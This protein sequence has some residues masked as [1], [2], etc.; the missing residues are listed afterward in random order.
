MVLCVACIPCCVPASCN[1]KPAGNMSS[2]QVHRHAKSWCFVSKTHKLNPISFLLVANIV[3]KEQ[4]CLPKSVQPRTA[5]QTT[6]SIITSRTCIQKLCYWIMQQ[7][8]PFH[9]HDRAYIETERSSWKCQPPFVKTALQNDMSLATG[10][11][12]SHNQ[13]NARLG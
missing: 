9:R 13:Q 4:Q 6:E 5:T 10:M 3:H 1:N 8:V 11:T 2:H 7:N 12:H